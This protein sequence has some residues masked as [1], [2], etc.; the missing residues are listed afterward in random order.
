MEGFGMI[1]GK[2]KLGL[3][4]PMGHIYI[5]QVRAVAQEDLPRCKRNSS[6]YPGP[7]GNNGKA[8]QGME[9]NCPGHLCMAWVRIIFCGKPTREAP[10]IHLFYSLVTS[11]DEVGGEG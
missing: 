5:Y 6:G 1:W 7:M 2:Q 10:T 11:V 8:G 9:N 4:G 3:A